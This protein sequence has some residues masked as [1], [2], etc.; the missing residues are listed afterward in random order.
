MG[1]L[2]EAASTVKDLHINVQASID[3]LRQQ[4]FKIQEASDKHAWML[5]NKFIRLELLELQEM[6]VK[7]GYILPEEAEKFS[8]AQPH[9]V[10]MERAARIFYEYVQNC[11]PE[12][13]SPQYEDFVKAAHESVDKR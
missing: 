2:I 3:S 11:V 8:S 9:G 12:F 10:R 13:V 7:A 4:Y 6:L 1:K 5:E